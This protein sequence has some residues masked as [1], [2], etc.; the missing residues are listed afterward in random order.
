MFKKLLMLTF[1]LILLV[2]STCIVSA[3]SLD[4]E[5]KRPPEPG[6]R[7]IYMGS[8]S[9][10]LGINAIGK[11]TCYADINCYSGVDSVRISGYLQRYNSGT[12]VTVQHWAESTTG[13]SG[14]MNKEY[15]VTSGYQYRW[16]VYLY[17]Y[18]GSNSES[19][20]ITDYE[21]Y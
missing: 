3:D 11:A 6:V 14:Y 18:E 13:N 8:V 10:S 9:A 12:W 15:Y 19:T 7:F 17:A 1:V 21:T 5:T 20:V 16:K 2:S 4:A